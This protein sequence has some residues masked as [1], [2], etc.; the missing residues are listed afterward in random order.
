MGKKPVSAEELFA[1]TE[2]GPDWGAGEYAGRRDGRAGIR[3][4]RCDPRDDSRGEGSRREG[5]MS[6]VK[7]KRYGTTAGTPNLVQKRLPAKEPI[8]IERLGE[9]CGYAG[10][11]LACL[12]FCFFSVTF[13][14]FLN[15]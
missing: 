12:L 11:V 14:L 3:P 10:S 13:I 9:K 2:F 5:N 6:A 15:S 8:R 7:T 1:E 4:L